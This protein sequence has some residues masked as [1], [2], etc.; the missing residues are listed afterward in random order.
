VKEGGEGKSLVDLSLYNKNQLPRFFE[1]VFNLFDFLVVFMAPQLMLI[2]HIS[3]S[4]VNIVCQ[5]IAS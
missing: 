1:S 4:L 5:K 2:M 3:S